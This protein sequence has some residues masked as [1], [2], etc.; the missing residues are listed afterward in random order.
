MMQGGNGTESTGSPCPSSF[1]SSVPVAA[2]QI[3]TVLSDEPDTMRVPSGENATDQTA[4]PWPSSFCSSVPVAVSQIRTVLSD[5]PDT[6]REPSGENATDK[7]WLPC[8]SSFWPVPTVEPAAALAAMTGV[9]KD[10][11]LPANG[12]P[13]LDTGDVATKIYY[14]EQLKMS[15]ATAAVSAAYYTNG[16]PI[17]DERYDHSAN[18]TAQVEAIAKLESLGIYHDHQ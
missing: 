18:P 15:D 8:P 11:T 9:P 16:L 14:A 7:T 5:E 2:S 3:R 4:S 6:M 10:R 17:L 1:C 13:C 12:I